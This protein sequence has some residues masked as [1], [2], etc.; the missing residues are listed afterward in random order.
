MSALR[1]G[2]GAGDWQNALRA[3]TIADSG[4][5]LRAYSE[6]RPLEENAHA[7]ADVGLIGFLACLGIAATALAQ[8]GHP[9]EGQWSGDWGPN[10]TTR[11]RV[12]RRPGLER[13]TVVG[14]IN[15][16]AADAIVL[17]TDDAEPVVPTYDAW[18]VTMQG[19]SKDGRRRH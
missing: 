5:G 6:T 2:Q 19:A 9:L 11:N 7:K 4:P 16:G 13:K 17:R 18:T 14:T 3:D 15:P 8:Y 10:A 1:L 12:L